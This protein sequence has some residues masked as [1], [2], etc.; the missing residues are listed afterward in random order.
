MRQ[1]F[2][3]LIDYT[4]EVTCRDCGCKR[5]A[6]YFF[7]V[8]ED[9]TGLCVDCMATHDFTKDRVGDN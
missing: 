8:R 9:N 3:H 5:P 7:G 1:M 2:A 4:T 6:L